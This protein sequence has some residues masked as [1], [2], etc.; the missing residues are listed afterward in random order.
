MKSRSVILGGVATVSVL[1]SVVSGGAISALPN[2]KETAQM[3]PEVMQPTE[4]TRE[5]QQI[6]QPLWL[7][8]TVTVGGLGLIG[9]ELWWFLFSKP[10]SRK[11][12]TQSGG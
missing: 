5:F 1:L 8:G 12:T 10:R 6:D 9:L 4:P 2:S 7:K 3:S 11:A